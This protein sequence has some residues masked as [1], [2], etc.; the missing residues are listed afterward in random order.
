M[1]ET[2]GWEELRVLMP[3]YEMPYFAPPEADQDSWLQ[4][5]GKT[6]DCCACDLEYQDD[7]WQA[8]ADG[9]ATFAIAIVGDDG[10]MW[11]TDCWDRW[12]REAAS[13]ACPMK[14]PTWCYPGFAF[15]TDCETCGEA[16]GRCGWPW[17]VDSDCTMPTS[18]Y[19]CG[20]CWDAWNDAQNAQCWD[21]WDEWPS[22][23][24]TCWAPLSNGARVTGEDGNEYCTGCWF[25]WAHGG[26][27]YAADD[28]ELAAA[29]DAEPEPPPKVRRV[30]APP[31]DEAENKA[32]NDRDV[33]RLRGW[34]PNHC[35]YHLFYKHV[36]GR[37]GCTYGDSEGCEREGLHTIPDGFLRR[38]DALESRSATDPSG[39]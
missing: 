37:E 34:F 28:T 33:K 32:R 26:E 30:G 29:D 8:E 11:C 39:N 22:A 9:D 35:A 24:L 27:Q 15:S 5:A 36:R 7:Y 1:A 6:C 2:M 23:C 38:V 16:L 20:R 25:D 31:Q 21:A 10:S 13:L 4:V 17:L 3:G 12:A 19:Y 18:E 14:I